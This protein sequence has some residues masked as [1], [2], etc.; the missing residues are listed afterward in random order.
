MIIAITGTPGT[1]KTEVAK[2]LSKLLGW[3]W[4]SLN[5][6][7][8][9]KNLY[10][11]YDEERMVKIVDIEK[12][13]EE[14]NVLATIHKNIIIESHY[15]HE[16]PCDIAI[17]LRADPKV[18]RERMFSKG[19]HEEKISENIEAEIMGV[20][21]E[22]AIQL[23]REVYEIDT[24]KK[25]PDVVAKKI[26]K[27][28]KNRPFIV[29][30]LKL[31]KSL[32]FEFRKPFGDVYSGKLDDVAKKVVEKLKG[33]KNIIVCVGDTSSYYLI[34][35]GLKPNMIIVD[36]KEKRRKAKYKIKFKGVKLKAKNPPGKITVEMWNAIENGI[37]KLPKNRVEII[38]DGE[39]DLAVL[40]CAIHLPIGSYIIYGHFEE[41]LIVTFLDEERKNHAKALF[42]EIIF[43]QG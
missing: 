36:G 35:H 6:I 25:R 16:M 38:I 43:L 27:I 9:E 12:L 15:A 5:E 21:K 14:V 8:A 24:T 31:P 33:K 17:V 28:I 40:P 18:L 3:P 7:A 32:V 2:A 42:E 37:K 10:Q 34:K 19:F 11:G 4:F 39:E 1:G 26:E 41:G 23:G 22:E 13:K 20:I 30:D 29:K